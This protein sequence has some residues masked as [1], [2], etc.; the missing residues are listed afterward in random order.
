MFAAVRRRSVVVGA[1]GARRALATVSALLC[2]PLLILVQS[3]PAAAA[4]SVAPVRHVF[5]IVLENKEFSETFGAGREFA[6]YLTQ[7]LPAE[8]ALVPNYFGIGHSSADNYIAM[9]GGQPP[10]F[11]SKEDCPDPLTTIPTTSDSNGVA[12]GGGGCVYPSNFKTIADQLVARRRT[13]KAYAQNIP[14]PCSLEHDAPGDY[15][16]KH[17]PFPFFLSV[18]ESGQCAAND[19]PLSEL[20][21]NLKRSPAN[22]SFIFPDE[23][24]DGHSDC[25][26][27]GSVTPAQ[28]QADELAQ[29]DAF[30]KEWVPQITRTHA[31]KRNGLLAI[32]F[33]EGDET[34][35]CCGEPEV[36]PDG[37]FP[38]GEAGLPGAGGG[39]TG[40]VLLSPFIKPGTTSEASYNH[41]SLLASIEDMFGLH[42]L[43]EAN[44][45]ATTTFGRDVFTV[46]P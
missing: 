28:E 11:A 4:A 34:L 2:V 43:G 40:A 8:G 22:V 33:D 39:Q 32:V 15:E 29:A 7:T 24:S 5:V 16:R 44:L 21:A 17:N 45:A 20:P 36:D 6:P 19:V 23:C 46:A 9:I 3:A 18:R 26:A 31:F 38:G 27:T 41:Y 42:R 13:W 14:S 37:S 10:T 30:L 12:Q 25:T 1:A 35:A